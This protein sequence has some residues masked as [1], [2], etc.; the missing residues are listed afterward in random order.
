[1]KILHLSSEKTWRGGEQQIAY[2][3]EEQ[4]SLGTEV[5]VAARSGSKFA[6]FCQQNEFETHLLPFRN[7]LDFRTAFGLKKLL[8]QSKPDLIHVHSSKSHGIVALT[9]L[10]GLSTPVI[11][12]RRVDFKLKKSGFSNW[13]YNIPQIKRI[14]CVSDEIRDIVRREI[15]NP[16]R[17][18][19]VYSG[20][21]LNRFREVGQEHYLK[22]RFDLAHDAV[23]VGNTSAIADHKDYFTFIDTAENF[24][25]RNDQKAFFFIIGDG[26]MKEEIQ[27]YIA[28]KSLTSHIFMTG[29]LNNIPAILQEL[30][31]FLMTSKTEGLGTSVLDAFASHL[32]VVSTD[33]GGLKE[34]VKEGQ[35]GLTAS[36]GD[37]QKLSEQLERM[38]ADTTM[39]KKLSE[40]AFEF[41]QQFSKENTAALTQSIYREV[42]S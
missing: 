19:T 37:S 20:I 33:G 12:S 39:Q 31:V 14:I 38:I 26:P 1:M 32:P 9:S 13:K 35:T 4:R 18:K 27:Q 28:S 25:N 7:S 29:F 23:L 2:L 36:V 17:A 6:E 8:S 16:D 3:I 5:V 41:V 40:N 34:T 21:D 22:S 10:L 24:L 15:T 11:L 30:D 42:L